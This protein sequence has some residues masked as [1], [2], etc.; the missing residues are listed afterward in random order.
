MLFTFL[1]L[2]HLNRHKVGP[3]QPESLW[4]YGALQSVSHMQKRKYQ[5]GFFLRA[6]QPQNANH[7]TIIPKSRDQPSSLGKKMSFETSSLS[8]SLLLV[9]SGPAASIPRTGT[10]FHRRVRR[11]STLRETS[12]SAQRLTRLWALGSATAIM[13]W[14]S[15][16]ARGTSPF[17]SAFGSPAWWRW[18]AARSMAE[19]SG[20]STGVV[21]WKR[22]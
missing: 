18:K 20:V 10:A 14:M 13:L 5:H 22:L 6:A 8:P 16:P 7:I 17:T 1:D 11:Y 21:Q 12:A 4:Q 3:S 9:R 19:H 2:K 15:A